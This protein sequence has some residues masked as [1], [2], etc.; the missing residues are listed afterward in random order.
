MKMKKSFLYRLD[1]TFKLGNEPNVSK[2]IEH[3]LD[4]VDLYDSIID[5]GS[6]DGKFLLELEK[7]IYNNIKI[8]YNQ[9]LFDIDKILGSYYTSEY[10]N[11]NQFND[12]VFFDFLK[13]IQ[14]T[15]IDY[16]SNP[17]FDPDDAFTYTYSQMADPTGLIVLTFKILMSWQLLH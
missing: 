9:D 5:I 4:S 11:R 16:L 17:Y 8:E 2:L 13:W 14:D 12:V 7:R 15:N 1:N 6:N 3:L 10:Y